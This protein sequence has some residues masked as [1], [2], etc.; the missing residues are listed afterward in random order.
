MQD[1]LTV[2]VTISIASFAPIGSLAAIFDVTTYGAVGDGKQDDTQAFLKAWKDACSATNE[3]PTLKIPAAKTFLLSPVNFQGPCSFSNVHVQVLGNIVAPNSLDAW[4]GCVKNSWMVFSSVKNL[5]VDGSGQIDSQGS[6]WWRRGH[7]TPTCGTCPTVL[8]FYKCDNMNLSGLNRLNPPGNHISISTCTNVTISNLNITAPGDSPNTDGIDIS[9]SSQVQ[10]HDLNIQ[11]GDDCTAINNGC[12]YI[13]ITSVACGPGHGINTNV[14]CTNITME[15]VHI[16]GGLSASCTNAHG[17][18]VDT[19]PND[20]LTVFVTI[21]IASFA[22]IRGLAAVFDVR[23]YGAVGDG[24]KDDTQAFVKAWKDV[25]SATGGNPTLNI[26]AGRTFL[27][28]PLC[29]QGPCKFSTVHVQ[30]LGNLVAPVSLDA[31]KGCE[32]NSWIVF[33]TVN[34][35][36]V[37]G[38]GQINGQGSFWWGMDI[39]SPTCSTPTALRFFNCSNMNLHGL[40]HFNPPRNHISIDTC[41]GATIS[42]LRITAPENSPNTDGIDIS[43]TSQVQIRSLNIQTGDDCIAINSGSSY[44]NITIVACGPGHGISVGSLGA[45]RSYGTAEQVHVQNCNFTKTQNGCRIKTWPAVMTAAV[46]A[47]IA[48]FEALNPTPPPV[49]GSSDSTSSA[50]IILPDET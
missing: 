16:N 41:K 31:W 23:T 45:G 14:G 6:F 32:K 11:T 46:D 18:A 13:N 36:I 10:I 19:S 7:Q 33:S 29:F 1:A 20:A 22:P 39:K 43:A 8:H 12:S 26:P 2:F 25:C 3:S 5:I 44:I 28:G 9:F 42:N 50:P 40:N 49:E 48:S 47:F 24:K 4:K 34:N 38:S 15:H 35:L 21:C 27:V 30:V 17:T 37:D